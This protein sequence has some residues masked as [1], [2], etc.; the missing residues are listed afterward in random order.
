MNDARCSELSLALGEPLGATATTAREWLLVEVRGGWSREVTGPDALPEPVHEAI[1]DWLARTPES[2]LLFVRRL[3]R[4]EG[5][6]LAFRVRADESVAEVRRLEFDRLEDLVRLELAV[7]GEPSTLPLVLVCGHGSRDPCCARHGTAVFGALV[8]VLGEEQLWLSSHQ[9]GHRF[10]A[11]VLV[12]P[13]GLQLGRVEPA[14]AQRVIA[15]ALGGRIV[16]SRYRGRT[17]YERPVQAA[18]LA[19]RKAAGLDGVDDLR[20]LEVRGGRVHFQDR[21]GSEHV[22]LVEETAGPIVP[23]SCGDEPEPQTVFTARVV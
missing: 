5:R 4:P 19:T 14:D 22:A 6:L 17:W 21:D 18:E 1:S 2:R 11:N 9:G 20:L 10:A 23:A 3:D 13:A 12:L 15:V 7:A 16:L 8:P